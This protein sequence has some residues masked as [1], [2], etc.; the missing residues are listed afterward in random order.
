MLS[1]FSA[2][3]LPFFRKKR[4]KRQAINSS[5]CKWNR[6][7]WGKILEYAVSKLQFSRIRNNMKSRGDKRWQSIPSRNR[8][9]STICYS[10]W[11]FTIMRKK[12]NERG[13]FQ[14][15]IPVEDF[16][17]ERSI[18][19]ELFVVG[20]SLQRSSEPQLTDGGRTGMTNVALTS[21]LTHVSNYT[22][23]TFIVLS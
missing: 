5:F 13:G 2:L 10:I 12:E 3:L 16:S 15:G 7:Q 20:K 23:I 19:Y 22:W 1:S 21:S 9:F 8:H 11:Y 14:L 18:S 17:S 6:E 4:R